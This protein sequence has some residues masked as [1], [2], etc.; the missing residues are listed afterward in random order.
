MEINARKRDERLAEDRKQ[1][2]KL[3]NIKKCYESGETKEYQ[4]RMRQNLISNREELEVKQLL[5]LCYWKNH[6]FSLF[7]YVKIEIS[8]GCQE[9]HRSCCTKNQQR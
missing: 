5:H 8:T 2:E 3:L 1:L 7:L 9:P 6:E 4:K